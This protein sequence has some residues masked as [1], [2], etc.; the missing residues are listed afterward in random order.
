MKNLTAVGL[1]GIG[2]LIVGKNWGEEKPTQK[3]LIETKGEAAP[4]AVIFG[5]ILAIGGVYLL[6]K[7]NKK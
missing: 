3:E 7:E 4:I 6:L 2:L 5:S 1:V